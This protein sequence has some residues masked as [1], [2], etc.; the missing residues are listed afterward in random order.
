MQVVEVQVVAMLALLVLE[1]QEVVELVAL[2]YQQ[3][4]AEPLI[5]AVVEVEAALVGLIFLAQVAQECL[6]FPYQQ[7]IILEQ[8]Q[9]HLQ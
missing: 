8:P 7:L 1:V 9:V 2:I 6:F 5:E 4:Q 3:E